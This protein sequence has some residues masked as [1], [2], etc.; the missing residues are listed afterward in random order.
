[1]TN[2]SKPTM[3][4]RAAL[5]VVLVA[6]VG[7]GCDKKP[8]EPAVT[9]D[10][11]AASATPA[12]S[13][14]TASGTSDNSDPVKVLEQ[15]FAAAATGKSDALKGLCDPSGGGDGDVKDIC[16][17][18]SNDAKWGEFKEYFATGQIKGV[19]RVE[20]DRAEIDFRFGPGGSKED[21]M[22]LSRVDGKWYL[23]SF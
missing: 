12:P 15:V 5:A 2:T 8:K 21:T 22:K 4:R 7:T 13:A 10:K 19:A 18:T 9:G 6:A 1:M 20:G 23:A 11:P 14:P 16:G 17:I 3:L